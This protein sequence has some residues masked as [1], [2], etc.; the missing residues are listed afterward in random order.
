MGPD[1]LHLSVGLRSALIHP[2]GARLFVGAG[3]VAGSTADA[4][5]EE[6]EAKA[7]PMLRAV[8]VV[9]G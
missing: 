6:T 5:W 9:H 3:V 4:E 1:G 7:R 2:G 8:G